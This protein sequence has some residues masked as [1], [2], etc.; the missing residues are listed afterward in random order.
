M[1]MLSQGQ[2]KPGVLKYVNLWLSHPILS[3]VLRNLFNYSYNWI[4]IF[5]SDSV[6][7]IMVMR[8]MGHRVNKFLMCDINN[9][10]TKF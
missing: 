4:F 5:S 3:L 1:E 7:G 8:C 9:I 10:E 6:V 2:F